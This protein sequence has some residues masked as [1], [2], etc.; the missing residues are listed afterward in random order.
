MKK[1]IILFL[2]VLV[3]SCKE[4][5]IQIPSNKVH[6]IVKFQTD[7]SWKI[8]R[9]VFLKEFDEEGN[10]IRF[11]QFFSNGNYLVQIYFYPNNNLSIVDV[12]YYNQDN[13]LDSHIK[14]INYFNSKNKLIKSIFLNQSGDT[15]KIIKFSYDSLGNLVSQVEI[16]KEN[17]SEV[18]FQYEY[19][20]NGDLLKVIKSNNFEPFSQVIEEFAYDFRK[21]NINLIIHYSE[22][23]E[24]ENISFFY[25]NFGLITSE[26]HTFYPAGISEYYIYKYTFY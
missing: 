4:N 23:D 1:I 17:I 3:L 11:T 18:I 24:F 5:P 20:P 12:N 10:L 26:I 15:S 8:L 16:T 6:T 13:K 19:S 22:K 2:I 21:Q 9:K 25:N 7:S 14:K